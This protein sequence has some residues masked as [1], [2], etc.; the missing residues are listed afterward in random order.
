MKLAGVAMQDTLREA[1]E[2]VLVRPIRTLLTASGVIIGVGAF[3]ATTGVTQTASAQISDQFDA[4]RST[5]VRVQP[6]AKHHDLPTNADP[7]RKLNGVVHAGLVYTAASAGKSTITVTPSLNAPKPDVALIAASPGALDASRVSFSKGRRYD[8]F[9]EDSQALVALVGVLAAERLGTGFN[10]SIFINGKSFTVAGVIV[11]A[12]RTEALLDAVVIPTTT[13]AE[14]VTTEPDDGQILIETAPGAAQLIG[15]QAVIA[16]RPDNP[17]SLRALVPPDP[18]TLRQ[19]IERDVSTLLYGLSALALVVGALAIT[20]SQLLGVNERRNEIGLRRALGAKRSSIITQIMLESAMLGA[21]SGAAGVLL[22]LST[23][24]AVARLNN[25]T[26][27]IEPLA[28]VVAGPTGLFVAV[29]A[30]LLPAYKASRLPPAITLRA[31]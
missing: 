13:A 25:W 21:A 28:V 11:E 9:H 29:I 18:A 14:F 6:T 7:L 30:G 31:T 20:N 4:T 24:L 26:P 15:E 23:V 19:S 2:S 12:E 10:R 8:R 22:G 3:V 1:F 27:T 16:L 5:E 17:K